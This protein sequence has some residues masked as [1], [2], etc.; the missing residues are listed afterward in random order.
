M[1]PGDSLVIYTD[2]VTEAEHEEQQYGETRLE[3]VITSSLQHEPQ[4]IGN[5]LMADIEEFVGESPQSDD[6]TMMILK[7]NSI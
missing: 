1:N 2:G 5:L 4:K 7:R 3:K 6:I